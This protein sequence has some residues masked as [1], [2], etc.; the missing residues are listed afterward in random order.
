MRRGWELQEVTI[1]KDN[2][3]LSKERTES[4]VVAKERTLELHNYTRD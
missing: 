4:V 1:R 2:G 3:I